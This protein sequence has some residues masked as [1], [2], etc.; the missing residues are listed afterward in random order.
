[1]DN[2][3]RNRKIKSMNKKKRII[4]N[5]I[6]ASQ[7]T[8]GMKEG[9][10]NEQNPT[11]NSHLSLHTT[12][13]NTALRKFV[14]SVQGFGFIKFEAQFWYKDEIDCRKRSTAMVGCNWIQNPK[15]GKGQNC[16]F[17]RIAT[18]PASIYLQR[19]SIHPDPHS[20]TIVIASQRCEREKKRNKE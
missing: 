10:L 12:L 6:Y 5:A 7:M 18:P 17:H 13:P 16:Q 19:R 20:K 2:I 1:M 4:V 15:S 8:Y 9:K 14:D 3:C 11:R